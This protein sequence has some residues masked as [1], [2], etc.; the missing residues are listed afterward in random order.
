MPDALFTETNFRRVGQAG[1][2][3]S[4]GWVL[5]ERGGEARGT[6]KSELEFEYL[7]KRTTY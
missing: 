2:Y 1:G 4:P 7:D 3:D 5:G 6:P